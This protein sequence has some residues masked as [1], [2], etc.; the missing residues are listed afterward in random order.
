[1]TPIRLNPDD[2]C[3]RNQT[4]TNHKTSAVLC[5]GLL[6]SPHAALASAESD[7]THFQRPHTSDPDLEL[8]L[9]ALNIL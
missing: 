6:L 4:A 7:H 1:M 9:D 8:A 5:T 3:K 2:A